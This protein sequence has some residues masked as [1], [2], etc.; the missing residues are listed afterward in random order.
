MYCANMLTSTNPNS[1]HFHYL[2]CPLEFWT[3]LRKKILN[4]FFTYDSNFNGCAL[5][6]VSFFFLH[7]P[8]VNISYIF[9]GE[10]LNSIYLTK[11]KKRVTFL[12]GVLPVNSS[13]WGREEGEMFDSKN[14]KKKR[15]LLLSVAV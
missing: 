7:F 1:L 5:K 14:C 4:K 8:L 12:M 6:N 15:I 9:M 2:I 10:N 3:W 11:K 13:S